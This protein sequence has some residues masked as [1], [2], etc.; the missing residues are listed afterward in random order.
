[1]TNPFDDDDTPTEYLKVVPMPPP[2]T[3]PRGKNKTIP[4]PAGWKSHWQTSGD[5]QPLCN[6]VNAMVCL[7]FHPRFENLLTYNQMSEYITVNKQVPNGHSDTNLPRPLKDVDVSGVQEEMQRTGLR[8]I[9]RQV[10]HDAVIATAAQAPFHP[11][12]IYLDN[13]EWDGVPRIDNW[14]IRYMG[15]EAGPYAE[16]IGAMFLISMVAR[17]FD[18]GCK[19][20]YMLILEGKQGILKSHACAILAGDW[21]SDGLPELKGGSDAVRLSMH[22]RGKWLIEVAEM[23]SFSAT[24]AT[25]LKR[26]LS[27]QVER[28]T[29]KFGRA[30]VHEPRQCTFVGTTN[31]H[32][33]LRDSTGGRRFW[34]LIV[35]SVDIPGLSAARDQ[36]FAEAVARYRAGDHWWPDQAFEA[37][38]IKPEQTKRFEGDPWEERIKA[39][40]EGGASVDHNGIPVINQFGIQETREKVEQ[41]T[42]SALVEAALGIPIGRQSL[43]ETYRA[44]AI[45]VQMGW[46]QE[47]SMTGRFYS[48][49]AVSR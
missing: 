41:T 44:R 40:L 10:V 18:P 1:M 3:T 36:L 9:A 22:L 34:P 17:I 19:V 37:E 13:L 45:L 27:Q 30:E 24:E 32:A 5:G 14:L 11:V 15:A 23:S 43:K 8:R 21:Y 25:H 4:K 7:R 48:R 33:Y 6:L 16:R 35:T 29:P 42:C 28:F 39:W 49:P 2:D 46:T 12:R 31:E 26:F 20:D 38:F 47:R